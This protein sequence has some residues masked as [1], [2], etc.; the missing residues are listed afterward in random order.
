LTALRQTLIERLTAVQALDQTCQQQTRRLE[1]A[2]ASLRRLDARYQ[3]EVDG[4]LRRARARLDRLA[5]RATRTARHLDLTP[6]RPA[7][8]SEE[9][10]ELAGW[11]HELEA[12][13]ADLRRQAEQAAGAANEQATKATAATR[14]LLAAHRLDSLDALDA[15]R[16]QEAATA[17]QAKAQADEACRQRPLAADLDR[18]L[19]HGGT[20]LAALRAARDLLG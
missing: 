10:A 6:P 2:N 20:F 16:L 3:A 13:A 12:A 14:D 7:P 4:P 8:E 15:A 9:A 17:K 19:Q 1:A 11:A 18:R 5:E